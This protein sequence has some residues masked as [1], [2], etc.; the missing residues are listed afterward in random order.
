MALVVVVKVVIAV[1]KIMIN[2]IDVDFRLDLV[3]DD[4]GEVYQVESYVDVNEDVC[5]V[6]EAVSVYY[7]TNKGSIIMHKLT[8][9]Q[10][11]MIADA[12]D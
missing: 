2:I 6:E 7:E 9:E 5:V 12:F 3:Y 4:D 10:L 1:K 8:E 11:E